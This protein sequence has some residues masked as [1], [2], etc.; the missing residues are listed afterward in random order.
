[1]K[2]FLA[3]TALLIVGGLMAFAEGFG[4][5]VATVTTTRQ[6]FDVPSNTGHLSILNQ[7]NTTVYFAFNISTSAFETLML[8]TNALPVPAGTAWSEDGDFEGQ[9]V[10]RTL[11]DVATNVF[12][13]T[14]PKP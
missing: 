2:K 10:L 8:T 6:T 4:W 12:I 13:S 5:T 14:Y 3:V 9:L 11:A 7:G 1:M